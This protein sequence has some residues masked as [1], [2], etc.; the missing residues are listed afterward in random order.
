MAGIRIEHTAKLRSGARRVQ[1]NA[2]NYDYHRIEEFAD[3][4]SCES[5]IVQH[6]DSFRHDMPSL[7]PKIEYLYDRS[8]GRGHTSF[9][10]WTK[11]VHTRIK[12]GYAGGISQH[13]IEQALRFIGT[14]HVFRIWLDMETSVRDES[15]RFDIHKAATMSEAAFAQSRH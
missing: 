8:G 4:V 9:D 2:R 3:V 15:D 6:R 7:H 1:I 10:T 14:L 13:N 11:P 5:V 12:H